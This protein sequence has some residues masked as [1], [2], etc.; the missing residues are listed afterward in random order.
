MSVLTSNIEHFVIAAAVG[1]RA[2]G[3]VEL[4][5]CSRIAASVQDSHVL[6]YLMDPSCCNIV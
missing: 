6:L 1:V 4:W 2:A 5:M 3:G